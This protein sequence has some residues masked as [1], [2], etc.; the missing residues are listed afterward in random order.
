MSLEVLTISYTDPNA[1]EL[2]EYSLK[3]SG[4]AVIKDHPIP[5]F[6]IETVYTDWETFFSNEWT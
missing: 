5:P 6:L 3:N 1:P 2:F 4:F